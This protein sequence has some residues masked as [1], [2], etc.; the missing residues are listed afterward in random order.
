MVGSGASA[1]VGKLVITRKMVHGRCSSML[2]GKQLK[3]GVWHSVGIRNV[4]NYV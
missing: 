4:A 2:G 3:G 1:G